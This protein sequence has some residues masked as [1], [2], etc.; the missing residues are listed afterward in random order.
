VFELLL[1][2]RPVV[3]ET[4]RFVWAAQG[5]QVAVAVA[6]ALAAAAA[7]VIALH[8]HRLTS[9]QR[10]ALGLLR[11]TVLALVAAALLRPALLVSTAIAQ[12]N[13]LGILLDDSQSMRIADVVR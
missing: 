7:L 1:K 3:F 5:W 8:R 9:R 12:R 2:Y 6:L 10:V 13:V 11:A 4:C